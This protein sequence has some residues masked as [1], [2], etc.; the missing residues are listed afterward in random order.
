MT[1]SSPPVSVVV[2]TY[3]NASFVAATLRSIRDQS[4]ADFELVVADHA[5]RDDTWE[6]V[7]SFAAEDARVRVLRTERGGGAA[8]NWNR[9][10]DEARGRMLKLVCADDLLYPSCLAEQVSALQ[11]NPGVSLVAAK[12]DVVDANGDLLV[13]DRGLA[14]MTGRVPGRVAI[15]RSVV[16]GTNPFGEPAC[17][18]MLAEQARRAGGWSAEQPY[19]IDQDM[20]VKV[21]RMGD[22]V[23]LPRS[24]AA[25]RV[26]STQWSVALAREHGSQARA[27]YRRVADVDST[28]VRPSDV[29]IGAS[30]GYAYALA[31]RLAY[32]WWARR[33]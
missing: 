2:P 4:F 9:V 21:L 23:A 13:R 27:F 26:S 24:L 3:N 12:R 20:Y 17:V 29:A 18:L 33:M 7:S 16:S 10:T 22:L 19:F 32:V 8:R 15:R 31:R 11:E 1:S 30:R 6:I 14:G 5:S 28:V 25:F